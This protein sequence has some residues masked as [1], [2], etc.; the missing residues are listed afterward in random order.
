MDLSELPCIRSSVYCLQEGVMAGGQQ[1]V[2]Y[3]KA[4]TPSSGSKVFSD[5][6]SFKNETMMSN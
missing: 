1:L 2:Y 3:P 5:V 6:L 4:E